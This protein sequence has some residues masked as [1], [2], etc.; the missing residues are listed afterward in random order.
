M[1][2]PRY[3][4]L[5]SVCFAVCLA[6]CFL[7]ASPVA[8]GQIEKPQP[9]EL[10]LYF[11]GPADHPVA[12]WFDTNPDLANIKRNSKWFRQGPESVM[13]QERY[14]QTVGANL[15]V[16]VMAR[17]S[18]GGTIYAADKDALPGRSSSL[19]VALREAYNASKD[20]VRTPQPGPAQSIGA[21]LPRFLQDDGTGEYEADCVGPNCRVP[22]RD[23]GQPFAPEALG[24]GIR[25]LV[26]LIGGVLV[27]AFVLIVFVACVLV[28]AVV[29]WR[30]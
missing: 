18:D 21:N 28:V 2:R 8:L 1:M 17:A 15:P 27:F 12:K 30:S 5:L 19:F 29:I 10:Q 13:F 7:I 9:E 20:A 26:W 11:F 24:D 16:L 25:N 23:R 3:L 6:G 22:F 4:S 14:A